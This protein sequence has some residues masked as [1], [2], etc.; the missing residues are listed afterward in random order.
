MLKYYVNGK[1]KCE[2][3]YRYKIIPQ[4]KELKDLQGLSNNYREV[5]S[6]LFHK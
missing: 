3:F 1:Y 6:Q 2:L 5:T 4:D